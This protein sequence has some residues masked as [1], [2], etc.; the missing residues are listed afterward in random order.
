M[1]RARRTPTFRQLTASEVHAVLARNNVG[2]LAYSFRDLVDIEP[3]HYV[4]AG[5]WIYGRTS[6]GTKLTMLAHN[7]WVAF[8]VDEIDGLFEWR[9]VVVKG[10]VYV[11]APEGTDEARQEFDHALELLRGLIPDTLTESDPTPQRTVLFRI[12]M[13]EAEGRTATR[14][15]AG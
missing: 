15:Q 13:D 6:Y 5:E 8:E 9:S 7:R 14:H 1:P 3:I 10:A 4:H 2:R 11:L 12:S